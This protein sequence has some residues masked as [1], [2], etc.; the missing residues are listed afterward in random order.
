MVIDGEQKKDT[1][2]RLV[3]DT[4]DK[5]PNA[6]KNSVI[7]FAD[8][9]SSIVGPKVKILSPAYN[10]DTSIQAGVPSHLVDTDVQMDLIYTAETHNM[11]TGVCPFAGAETGTGGRLRDVQ[12]T[13]RGAFPVAGISAYCMGN[14][15]LE[16][17]PLPWEEAAAYPQVAAVLAK[18]EHKTLK[19]DP[20]GIMPPEYA[21]A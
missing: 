2:F 17:Y 1:L 20:F 15:H 14:L 5:N 8:N 16:G 21:S 11:P 7:A 9:S 6:N 3:K 18:S 19:A 4:L 10:S 13:G 12:A